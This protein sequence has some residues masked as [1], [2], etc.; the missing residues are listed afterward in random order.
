LESFHWSVDHREI[1]GKNDTMS[2]ISAASRPAGNGK[3]PGSWVDHPTTETEVR[4]RGA[5]AKRFANFGN[6]MEKGARRI[7]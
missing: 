2:D 5:F 7:A 1:A 4:Q 3:L 6:E